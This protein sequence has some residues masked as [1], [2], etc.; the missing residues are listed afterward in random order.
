MSSDALWWQA[1]RPREGDS[2]DV[3]SNPS[4]WAQVCMGSLPGVGLG[5]YQ[6]FSLKNSER[7]GISPTE[8]S[9]VLMNGADRQNIVQCN[10]S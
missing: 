8:Y 4:F 6:V 7:Q 5:I 1:T 9:Q 3:V 2:R 10:L